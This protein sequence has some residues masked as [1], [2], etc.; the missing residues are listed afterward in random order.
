MKL[1]CITTVPGDNVLQR[2]DA[3]HLTYP[4]VVGQVARILPES[5][6]ASA[7]EMVELQPTSGGVIIQVYL[8]AGRPEYATAPLS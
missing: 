4:M 8:P 6:P 2:R 1:T 3:S 7:L 5:G